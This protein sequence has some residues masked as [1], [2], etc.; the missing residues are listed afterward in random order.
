MLKS[1]VKSDSQG[2]FPVVADMRQPYL[3]CFVWN[4][5][6]PLFIRIATS[7]IPEID[8]HKRYW[9]IGDAVLDNY[10][11]RHSEVAVNNIASRCMNRLARGYYGLNS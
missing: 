3:C 2:S 5:N 6:R 1:I 8:T 9:L 11:L 7:A 4:G 10:R